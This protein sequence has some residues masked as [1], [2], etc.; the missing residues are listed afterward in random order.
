MVG[1]LLAILSLLFNPVALLSVLA[2]VFCSIGLAKVSELERQDKV[3]GRRTA[4]TGLII[5][6]VG[7]S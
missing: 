7:F 6:I 4:L 3:S 2:I 5:G 1:C